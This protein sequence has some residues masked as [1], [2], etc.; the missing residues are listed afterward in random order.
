MVTIHLTTFI[1]APMQRVYDLARHISVLKGS[2]NGTPLQV[3]SGAGSYLLQRGDTLT[4]QS[5]NLGKTRTV[6]ARIT[7]MDGKT[8]FAEE[9]VKGDLKSYRH[10]HH[11]KHADN[12]TIMID[13]IDCE[14]PR[15][16]LGSLAGSISLKKY[17]EKVVTKRIAQIRLY[18]ESDKWKAV[19]TGMQ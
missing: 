4:F 7:E 6:T 5:K 9:Q 12:G 16:L 18:A 3:S 15:D 17:I 11:F 8:L 2:L 1:E 19:L 10:T 13:M 14:G